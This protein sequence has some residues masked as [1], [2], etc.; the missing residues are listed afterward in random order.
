MKRVAITG[1]T[2]FVGANLAERLIQDG[3]DVYLLIREGHQS[4]RIEHLLPHLHVVSVNLLDR[5]ELLA[6]IKQIRPDWVFHLAAYGAYSWQE[7]LDTAIQTNFL[8][9]VN[10]VE[11]CREVGFE[12][13]INTGSSSEYGLKGYAPPEDDF[14]DPNSYYAVTKAST[15]LFCRYTAQRF[16]LPIYTLRLYSVYGPYEDPKRLIPMM[17]LKGLQGT[18]PP[19]VHPDV[20]RDFIFTEDVNNACIFV[21]SSSSTL[22]FGSVYNIGTGKQV[23]LRDIVSLTRNLFNI[24]D[25]PEWGS[26]ENRPWDTN[27]WVANNERLTS[28]GWSPKYD[29]Q[30][31]YMKTIEWYKQNPAIVKRIYT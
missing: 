1:A 5:K 15:T 14:L 31:G 26:M 23:A 4:W 7:N 2:G 9:A 29:F 27:I 19:L 6:S 21:A 20:A 30:S 11:V 12:A 28:A 10:L 13:F 3:H 8:S 25:E 24:K 16:N 17:I 18:L 22:P